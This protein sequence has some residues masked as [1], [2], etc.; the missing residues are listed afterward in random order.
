MNTIYLGLGS[1]LGD[2]AENLR[3]AL[4][5][6]APLVVVDEKSAIY[7]SVPH[8]VEEQPLYFNMAVSATTELGPRD[9]LR[10]LKETEERMGRQENTHNQPRPIDLDIL[11]YG[12]MV[13]ETP[14]LT[15]PHPRMHERAF[16]LVPLDEIASFHQH[17]I[18]RKPIIDLLDEL[19]GHEDIVWLADV[20]V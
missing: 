17:P 19:G 14:E 15:I 7:E 4:E 16:V 2:R 1:N 20:E 8:G 11:L 12:D 13:L 3:R 5:L 10:H 18:S 9:L 6:L